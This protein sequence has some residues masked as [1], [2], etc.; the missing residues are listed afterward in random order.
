MMRSIYISKTKI[1]SLGMRDQL[2]IQHTDG[3]LTSLVWSVIIFE[4]SDFGFF[5]TVVALHSQSRTKYFRLIFHC[6]DPR[7]G[8]I[9]LLWAHGIGPLDENSL[10]TDEFGG[11][12]MYSYIGPNI[13]R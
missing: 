8:N 3:I 5:S 1:H 9:P 2:A 7:S 4:I 12:R 10:E 13:R 11:I 6:T